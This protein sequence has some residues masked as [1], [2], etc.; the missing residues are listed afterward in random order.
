M[1]AIKVATAGPLPSNSYNNSTPTITMSANGTV[2][3][4]GHTLAVNE[5]VLVKDESDDTH[6]G[7]YY[8]VHAGDG[9]NPCVLNGYY[10]EQYSR[11]ANTSNSN[12]YY[13]LIVEAGNDNANSVWVTDVFGAVTFGTTPIT[14]SQ[15]SKQESAWRS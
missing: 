10:Q 1:I 6:N 7:I 2:V 9:S 14:F 12:P 3:V 15:F 4:D 13:P 8:V 11:I 5:L